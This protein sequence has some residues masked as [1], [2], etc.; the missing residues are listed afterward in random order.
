MDS[1]LAKKLTILRIYQIIRDYS[2]SDNPISQKNIGEILEQEYGLKLGR[3]AI[4]RNI[5]MLESAGIQIRRDSRNSNIYLCEEEII[6]S[7][8]LRLLIDSILFSKHIPK[9]YAE[10]L[11]KKLGKLGN[12]N[13]YNSLDIVKIL[14]D[15]YHV[16]APE[17]FLNID[18]IS[19]AMQKNLKIHLVYN[20][21]DLEK[22]LQPISEGIFSPY[23]LFV[24]DGFYYVLANKDGRMCS[25]VLRVDKITNI[26]LVECQRIDRKRITKMGGGEYEIIRSGE[27][28]HCTVWLKQV[29]IQFVID[30]FGNNFEVVSTDNTLGTAKIMIKGYSNDIIEWCMKYCNKVV[31]LEPKRILDELIKRT[32]DMQHSYARHTPRSYYEAIADAEI[33]NELRIERIC[34]YEKKDHEK[35]VGLK[36]SFFFQTDI[37]DF[38]FLAQCSKIEVVSIVECPACKLGG[39]ENCTLLQ[40]L[41]ITSTKI[42]ND[43]FL[44]NLELEGLTLINNSI[45]HYDGIYKMKSLKNLTIDERTEALLDMDRLGELYDDLHI[46]IENIDSQVFNDNDIELDNLTYPYN[47]LESIF[48]TKQ[49]YVGDEREIIET[50]GNI[51]TDNLDEHELEIYKLYFI[52]GKN[53][54]DVVNKLCSTNEIIELSVKRILR[55]L[56]HPKASKY[57]RKYTAM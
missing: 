17:L 23:E 38:R 30:S 6:E 5:A 52:E 47:V 19:E 21:Y 56:R 35:L 43:L 48:Q 57:L 54:K 40:H 55:K 39:L 36:S 2:D 18:L 49:P 51:I 10:D 16:Q 37:T 26:K 7:F 9:K 42:T 41:D 24:I 53:K 12:N 44:E 46:F 28:V 31:L 15:T 34:S 20:R 8:E 29:D 13:F 14:E 50:L 27:E 11:I 1:N 25:E 3:N 4:S 45:E 33:S 22:K 32:Q